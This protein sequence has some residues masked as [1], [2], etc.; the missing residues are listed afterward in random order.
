MT[1]WILKILAALVAAFVLY[2]LWIFGHILYWRSHNPDASSFMNEQLAKLQQDDPEAEL[3]HKWVPYERISPNLKRALIAAEDAKFVDHEGFD[4]DGIEAAFEK[5]LKKGRIVAGGST[6]SQ[7]LAKNLFLSSGKTPWRKLEEALITVMLEKAMDKRRIFE[8]YLNVIE[9]G[10]GVFGAEAAS[11]HYFRASASK[12]SAGQAAKLAAMV[13]NPRYYDDHRNAPG[14][15]K[16]TRIIQRRM[17][18][19]DLP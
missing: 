12:L 8:I 7:Q 10:N 18:Y 15:A 6:I 3:S 5:N 1:R 14:L 4:W 13:P 17:A 19:A 11:R 2:N 9:W 16:K